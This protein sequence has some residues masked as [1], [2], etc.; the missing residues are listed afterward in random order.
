MG[1]MGGG[2]SVCGKERDKE[3]NEESVYRG[4]REQYENVVSGKKNILVLVHVC[5]AASCLCAFEC[6]SVCPLLVQHLMPL[7][8]AQRAL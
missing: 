5:T 6:M 8:S 1:A 7:L 4:I 2:V 3:A